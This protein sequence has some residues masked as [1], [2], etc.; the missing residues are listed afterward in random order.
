MRNNGA[1]ADKTADIAPPLL[2]FY[3]AHGRKAKAAAVLFAAITNAPQ[4]T[5][6]LGSVCN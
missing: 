1:T 3:H 4:A 5:A 6:C 2:Q